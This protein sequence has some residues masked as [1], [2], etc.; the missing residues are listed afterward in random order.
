[1]DERVGFMQGM[2]IIKQDFIKCLNS[3]LDI[4]RDRYIEIDFYENDKRTLNAFLEYTKKLKKD[5]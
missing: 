1:M 5:S 4:L 3:I 2:N